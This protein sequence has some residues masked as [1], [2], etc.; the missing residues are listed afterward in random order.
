MIWLRAPN[1][2]TQQ[3]RREAKQH[4]LEKWNFCQLGS[5]FPNSRNFLKRKDG[6][7]QFNHSSRT[8]YPRHRKDTYEP[9][10]TAI[11]SSKPPLDQGSSPLS[12]RAEPEIHAP[13]AVTCSAQ[14]R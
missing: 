2:E 4:S 1:Q 11:C 12:R 10:I 7:E 3:S 8:A 5:S 6:T 13:Q 9:G 14:S